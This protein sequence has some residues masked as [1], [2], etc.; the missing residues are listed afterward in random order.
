MGADPFG[1]D[2]RT[3]EQ[4]RDRERSFARWLSAN[5]PDVPWDRVADA[6]LDRALGVPRERNQDDSGLV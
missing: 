2:P 4:D 1:W 3:A 6:L 5:D